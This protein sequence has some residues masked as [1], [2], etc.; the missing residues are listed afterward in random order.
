M[1]YL[2]VCSGIEAASAAWH[3]LGWTPV[4]FSEV[5][6]FPSAVLAHHFPQVPNFGDMTK[7][8]DWPLQPGDFDVLIGGTPCQSFSVAGLRKGMEDARGNLAL[9]FCE[10]VQHYRPQ[11]VLWENVPG[12]LSSGGGRDFGSIVGALGQLGYGWAYRVCDAQYFGVPQRRRRVFLV[13]YSGDWQPPASVLFEQESVRGYSAPRRKTR[14]GSAAALG[15][16]VE[17]GRGGSVIWR[18]G[19]QANSE[20]LVDVTGTLNTNRGQ[21]GG[22]LFTVPVAFNVY[23]A[24]GQGAELQACQ[25]DIANAV[26]VTEHA[27]STDRGTRIVQQAP[28]IV[29]QDRVAGPLDSHYFKGPGSRAGGEREYVAH[30]QPPMVVRRLT[31]MECERLQGFPDGWTDIPYRGKPAPDGPRYKALGNSMAVPVIRW[32]G[33]RIMAVEANMGNPP[34]V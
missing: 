1:R 14:K 22:L 3:G 27:K 23:P 25:T 34:E 29:T 6:A 12:V 4:G 7:F 28:M 17:D 32:L 21:K 13:G 11:W 30:V 19:D 5:D 8:R 2:S 18:A 31:P 10:M 24:S 20:T 26:T 33:E 16:G 15:A 9:V